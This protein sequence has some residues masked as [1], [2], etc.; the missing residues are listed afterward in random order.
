MAETKNENGIK[1]KI[2]IKITEKLVAK[3]L[4]CVLLITSLFTPN[5]H[6]KQ[7]ETIAQTTP[8]EKIN[9]MLFCFFENSS[10]IGISCFVKYKLFCKNITKIK[11]NIVIKTA[12]I[13]ENKTADFLLNLA[14]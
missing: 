1:L 8:T 13:S 12:K 11:I 9:F 7:V 10:K 14:S 6:A 5:K 3:K 2:K 4:S